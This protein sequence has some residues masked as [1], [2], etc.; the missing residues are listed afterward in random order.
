[1]VDLTRDSDDEN[2]RVRQPA[3]PNK[4]NTEGHYGYEKACL[5]FGPPYHEEG[6]VSSSSILW[7]LV[8][9]FLTCIND[10]VY[11]IVSSIEKILETSFLR[12]FMV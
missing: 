6:D 9:S 5:Y 8:L 1:M 7:S 10:A 2:N 3:R 11:N 4:Y 12:L